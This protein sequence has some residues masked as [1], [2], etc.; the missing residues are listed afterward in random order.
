MGF[1]PVTHSPPNDADGYMVEITGAV[2]SALEVDAV[3]DLDGA[4]AASDAAGTNS[5]LGCSSALQ[6][7]SEGSYTATLDVVGRNQ[8]GDIV[9]ETVSVLTG[10]N[11]VYTNHCYSFVAS[12]TCTAVSGWGTSADKLQIGF[13]HN[14]DISCPYPLS[15]RVK[16]GDHIQAVYV[17]QK[18]IPASEI[19][20]STIYNTATVDTTQSI[21]GRT[22]VESVATVLVNGAAAAY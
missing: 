19:T 18:L 6:F 2:A 21:S 1:T 11:E 17:G 4:L 22:A 12:I 10:T 16:S 5:Y 8:F 15:F 20:V 3:M 14:A 7:D 13:N 9:T